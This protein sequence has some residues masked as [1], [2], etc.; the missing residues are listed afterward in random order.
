MSTYSA[1]KGIKKFGMAVF[2]PDGCSVRRLPGPN[3]YLNLTKTKEPV[4]NSLAI[5][6]HTRWPVFK[7]N[8]D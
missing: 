4:D 8:D 1:N 7:V 6:C 2:R 3:S 5:V